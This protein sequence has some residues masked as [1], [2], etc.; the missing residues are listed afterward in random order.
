MGDSGRCAF[1]LFPNDQHITWPLISLVA[2]QG[3]GIIPNTSVG[4]GLPS[5]CLSAPAL[6]DSFGARFNLVSHL[7]LVSNLT[8]II[9]DIRHVS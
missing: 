1:Q 3:I 6:S 9:R 2:S 8:W 5:A 7:F 4:R